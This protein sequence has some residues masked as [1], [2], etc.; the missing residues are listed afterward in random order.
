MLDPAKRASRIVND[1]L[2]D[3]DG[4]PV[5]DGWMKLSDVHREAE[6]RWVAWMEAKFPWL[7]D[8]DV[9]PWERG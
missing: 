5:W 9:P 8:S 3:A 7:L 4:K 2:C 6:A 1:I